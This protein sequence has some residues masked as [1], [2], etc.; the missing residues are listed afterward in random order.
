M[1]CQELHNHFETNPRLDADFPPA[2][3]SHATSCASC[4]RFVD[5]QLALKKSLQSLRET[6]AE[7]PDTFD[8]RVL[9]DFRMRGLDAKPTMLSLG[10]ISSSSALRW[11][12]AGA[13]AL[14][15]AAI[16][17]TSTRR[18]P[19]ANLQT[20]TPSGAVASVS[21]DAAPL[22]TPKFP[23]APSMK[24]KRRVIPR[25]VPNQSAVA[26]NRLDNRLPA[27]FRSL[28]Y[29]DALTCSAP[30]QMIRVQIPSGLI[31]RPT[32]SL[33]NTS[34]A[35]NADVLIGSDGIARGIRIVDF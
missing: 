29:C 6:A 23:G 33:V 25:P 17:F 3:V 14:V 15:I 35:V 30:M 24:R 34:G 12:V 4:S 13:T 28:M 2:V 18:A 5:E 22:V 31:A 19:K 11:G 21:S 7:A 16:L 10:H 1:N 27:G 8:A 20:Q 26:S 9:A 32:P